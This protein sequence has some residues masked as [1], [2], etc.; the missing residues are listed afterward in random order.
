MIGG[1]QAGRKY[2]LVI[3]C[4]DR[5]IEKHIKMGVYGVA[6]QLKMKKAEINIT[7]QVPKTLSERVMDYVVSTWAMTKGIDQ[8]KVNQLEKG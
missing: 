4:T 2:L 8:E 3:L 1:T 5:L 6:W 7:F